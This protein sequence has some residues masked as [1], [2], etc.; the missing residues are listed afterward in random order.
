MSTDGAR[1]VA[2]L[3][4]EWG[5][6]AHLLAELSDREWT[7]AVLPGWDV[8]DVVAHLVGTERMLVGDEVPKSSDDA[9]SQPHVHNDI[10]RLNEA[11]VSVLRARSH[12]EVQSDF[13]AVTAERAKMLEAMSDDAFEAP[14]W[15]PAGLGTYGDFMAI[16]IFDTYMHEQDIRSATG[17]GGH[18]SGEVAEAAVAQVVK[19]LGYIVG[20]RAG[21]PQASSV[22]IRLLGPISRDLHVVVAERATVVASLPGPASATL[23]LSS[24]L[25]LRLTGGRVAPDSVLDEVELGGDVGLARQVL[26]HLAFTI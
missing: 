3:G 4:E 14:S 20:K 23:A 6:V 15:T 16:R 8:H 12:A 13:R 10:G 21:A 17:R 26:A 18:E 7:L 25:F 22:T 1:I 9:S 24:P 2:L 19:A 5:V 11:W